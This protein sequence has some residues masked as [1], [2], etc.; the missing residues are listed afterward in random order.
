M[1]IC[2]SSWKNDEKLSIL[3]TKMRRGLA[4]FHFTVDVYVVELFL[5]SFK[6]SIL[7]IGLL[8][9]YPF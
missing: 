2:F 6:K 5:E 1:A 7:E 3:V 9:Q 8:S 4:F